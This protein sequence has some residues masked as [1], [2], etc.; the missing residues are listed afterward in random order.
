MPTCSFSRRC[1]QV[2]GWHRIEFFWSTSVFKVYFTQL[3]F[4]IGGLRSSQL[5]GKRKRTVRPWGKKKKKSP[6]LLSAIY[7]ETGHANVWLTVKWSSVKLIRRQ[8]HTHRHTQTYII[9]TFK[10]IELNTLSKLFNNRTFVLINWLC[11]VFK[12]YNLPNLCYFR[13][14]GYEK[15]WLREIVRE[16]LK[17]LSN[18]YCIHTCSLHLQHFSHSTTQCLQC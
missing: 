5:S 18:C 10:Q 7:S 8:T 14:K 17:P 12:P 11:F 1:S 3:K 4:T 15:T 2:G 9:I 13:V 6:L 16:T